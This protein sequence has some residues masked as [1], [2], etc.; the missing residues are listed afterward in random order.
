MGSVIGGYEEM[1]EITEN[2]HWLGQSSVRISGEKV[3][4]IDPWKIRKPEKADVVLVTHAHF[5]HLSPEDIDRVRGPETVVIAPPD[6]AEKLG[7][8]ARS[9]LPGDTISVE[10]VTVEAVPAYNTNK[11]FHPPSN[12]WVG[13]VV[14]V[15][16]K[17]IYHAGDTD[18]IPEMRNLRDIDVALLPVGGT[19]TMTAREAAEAANT[20]EPRVA[21]PFH[22]GAVVGSKSDAEK[23]KE[24][25]RVPAEIL[26][27]EK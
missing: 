9:I 18:F 3:V 11:D 23:F 14:T 24:L 17:R 19:Y 25:C 16:G 22:Y 6:C 27:Q 13:Y 7:K 26:E 20:V 5:D 12:R 4:Y 10:G 21:V 2:I 1:S 15:G 8:G